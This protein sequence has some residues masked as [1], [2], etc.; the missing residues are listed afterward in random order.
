MVSNSSIWC[1]VLSSWHT[2]LSKKL[3]TTNLPRISDSHNLVSVTNWLIDWL[4]D[5][6]TDWL[7]YLFYLFI[8][9]IYFIYLFIGSLTDLLIY[10]FVGSFIPFILS[11]HAFIYSFLRCFV[12]LQ[13]E[14][15]CKAWHWGCTD[16][17]SSGSSKHADEGN[18]S[19]T[20]VAWCLMFLLKCYMMR[21]V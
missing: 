11:I 15:L 7:I 2:T 1:W 13:K 8:L 19:I 3:L 20:A 9:F 17:V 16:Q 18:T 5:W 4:I 10:S 14:P 6:L 12:N 21:C